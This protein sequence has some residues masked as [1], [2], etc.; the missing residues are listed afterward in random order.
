LTSL[1]LNYY[2]GLIYLLKIFFAHLFLNLYF[3][4]VKH[5]ITFIPLEL[6]T[7]FTGLTISNL[8]N[9]NNFNYCINTKPTYCLTLVGETWIGIFF[10][11]GETWI[12]PSLHRTNDIQWNNRNYVAIIQKYVK[13]FSLSDSIPVF[14]ITDGSGNLSNSENIFT[15]H[16][17]PT[18]CKNTSMYVL[19]CF[20]GL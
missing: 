1:S 10:K 14:P 9:I 20:I 8:E 16:K 5:I 7:S 19:K 4:Y 3:F 6:F 13:I 11:V 15:Y 2:E 12:S 17:P 18:T